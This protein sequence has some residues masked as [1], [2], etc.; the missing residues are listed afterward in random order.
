MTTRSVTKPLLQSTAKAAE[1]YDFR[2][3]TTLAREHSRVLELALETFAR[4]WGTQLTAKVRVRSQVTFEYVLM[5]TYDEY[6]ASLP[7]TTAMVLLAVEGQDSKAVLQLPT[8]AALSWFSHMLGGNGSHAETERKFT[9]IEQSLLRRLMADA[10]DDLRYSFGP[11]L[12]ADITVDSIHHNSQFAQAA[13]TSEL[14]IVASFTVQVGERAAQTTLAIPADILLGQ[15][16]TANPV[17]A[18]VDASELLLAQVSHVPVEVSLQFPEKRVR[19]ADI[20]ALAVGDLIS[21]GHAGHKPLDIAV[22]GH[23]LARAA[24]GATGARLACVITDIQEKN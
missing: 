18:L 16:G 19:P 15:L 22:D 13:A 11:L 1:V 20:L 9:Q 5:H 8:T 7:S 14:M 6:A 2:R 23:T 24:V 21:L 10:I 12:A 17:V 4:Q 3:P